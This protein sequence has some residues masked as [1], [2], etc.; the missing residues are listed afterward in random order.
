M[1][2]IVPIWR[3]RIRFTF[4]L[5]S[6]NKITTHSS[7]VYVCLSVKRPVFLLLKLFHLYH[8]IVFYFEI[9]EVPNSC[10]ERYDIT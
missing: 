3:S 6:L 1:R 7:V 10:I 5:S 4:N 8:I 2:I 9:Y